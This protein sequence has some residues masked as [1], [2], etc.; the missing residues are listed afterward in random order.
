MDGFFA[1][2]FSPR[3]RCLYPF[4]LILSKVRLYFLKKTVFLLSRKTASSIPIILLEHLL[5]IQY[6]VVL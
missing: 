1:L 5:L 3:C 2:R 4:Y 6:L